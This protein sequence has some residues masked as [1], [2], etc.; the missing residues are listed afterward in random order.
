MIKTIYLL[1]PK[2]EAACIA[3]EL[4]DRG[5]TFVCFADSDGANRRFDVGA[6]SADEK[7]LCGVPGFLAAQQAYRARQMNQEEEIQRAQERF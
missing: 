4:I 6:D 3:S 5:L 7:H 1:V 2:D